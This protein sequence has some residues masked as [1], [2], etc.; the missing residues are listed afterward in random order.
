VAGSS[1]LDPLKPWIEEQLRADPSIPS[2]RLREL[3]EE[4]GYEG[5]KTIFDDH[6]REIRP[7]F[8]RR[9]TYQRTLYR[10]GELLQLDLFEPREPISVGHGQTRRGFIVTAV[11]GWSRALAGALVFSKQAPD[12]LWGMSRCLRRLGALPERL[13]W[14]REGAIHAGG[15]RPSEEFAGF[16]GQLAVGWIIL[17][18]GDAEAKGLLERSHRF[19]RTNFE[20][21]RRFCSALDYQAQLDAGTERA[22]ARTHR[23]TRAVP[24][25]RLAEERQR[26]RPLPGRLP[27]TDRRFRHQGAPA[28]LPALRSQRLLARSALRRPPGRG[29]RIPARAHRRHARHRRARLPSPPQLRRRAHRH[30]SRPAVRARAPARRA[31]S[32]ARGRAALASPLRRLD[33]GMTKVS[34]LAHLFRALKAPAAARALPKLAER[35]RQEQ[36]GYERFAEALLSTEVASGESHGG[37]SRIKAARFPARKPL[38]EFDFTFQR[39]VRKQVIEHLGQLDFLHTKENVVLLG[40]PGTGKT[41]LAI[42]LSIRACLAGQRVAFAT[43]TEWVARLADAKRQGNLETELRRLGFVPLVVVDEVGYIP[44][45]PE[46][47]NP[48]FSLVSARYER[49]SMIVTSNKPFSAWGEIFGDEVVAAAMID[50]LVHHAEILALKGDS[51]R[52]RDKDLGTPAARD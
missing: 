10:P 36:W 32:R 42:A 49:A 40:P 16:C 6:V 5:G 31:A 43:A 12:L 15:G 13:V 51:Y 3:A 47:A 50:R 20:P 7:R 39:S 26:M 44:F 45:D 11:L 14:D 52:L 2:K 17:D 25:E 21:G 27:D 22:N 24:A 28:A 34:E 46:A 23:T 37:E 29:P 38:E 4:L 41:H 19:M 48:M 33:P 9:R 1:K 18:A 35:A 30:R 8:L